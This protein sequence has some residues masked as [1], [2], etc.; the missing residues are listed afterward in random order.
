MLGYSGHGGNAAPLARIIDD[1]VREDAG[2]SIIGCTDWG[3]YDGALF[4]CA[5]SLGVGKF[6]A[7]WHAGELET[8]M[9][10][11]LAPELV[12]MDRAAPDFLGDLAEVRER[13]MGAGV[14]AIAPSGVLGDPRSATPEHGSAYLDALTDSITRFFRRELDRRSASERLD[15]T[16]GERPRVAG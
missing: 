16:S 4:P 10:L 5:E 1:L 12:L 11:K 3:V 8:S 7:G 13:L 2:R 14:Q 15:I 9:I 6:A